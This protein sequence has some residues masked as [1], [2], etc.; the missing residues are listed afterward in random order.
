MNKNSPAFH[1]VIGMQ[2]E[3]KEMET[4]DMSSVATL[5]SDLSST[6]LK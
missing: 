4:P 5:C 6:S 3:K 1:A 2:G